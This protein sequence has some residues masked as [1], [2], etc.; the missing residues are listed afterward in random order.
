MAKNW[1]RINK[2]ELLQIWEDDIDVFDAALQ[3]VK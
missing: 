1:V 3:Q 2:D